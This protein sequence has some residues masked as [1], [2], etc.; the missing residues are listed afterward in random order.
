[1]AVAKTKPWDK[2]GMVGQNLKEHQKEDDWERVKG[3]SLWLLHK[4]TCKR[5]F[6]PTIYVER[7]GEGVCSSLGVRAKIS[8]I[9]GKWLVCV[10]G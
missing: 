10:D 7:E 6:K 2:E 8:K 1:M 5:I 3:S 4:D 9:Q